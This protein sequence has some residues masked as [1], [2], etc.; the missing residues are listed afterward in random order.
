METRKSVSEID[1]FIS[2]LGAACE[3]KYMNE[4]LQRL[5]SQPDSKRKQTVLRLVERLSNEGAPHTLI[6]ALSCLMDDAVAEKAYT[7]I[8]QCSR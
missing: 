1:G 3:D 2:M 7:V 5:L 8:Y 6:E 4:T